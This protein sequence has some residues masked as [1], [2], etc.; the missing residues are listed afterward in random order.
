MAVREAADVATASDLP[1]RWPGSP[2]NGAPPRRCDLAFIL[3][4]LRLGG[5][6]RAAT[7]LIRAW[8]KAGIKVCVITFAGAG[9]DF[10]PLAPGIDRIGLDVQTPTGSLWR[11]LTENVRR[12]RLLRAAIRTTGAGR[13]LSFVAGTN[14]LTVLAT[15]GLRCRVVVSER[16]DPTRQDIGR[17]WARLRRYVYPHAD[18]VTANSTMAIAS[19]TAFVPAERLRLIPNSVEA[20]LAPAERVPERMFLAVGRLTHQKGLDVLLRAFA[21][22][23]QQY[24]WRLTIAG[25]GEERDSLKDLAKSL[26]IGKYV[27][28]VGA[29]ADVAALYRRAGVFVLSSRF[30]GTPNALLEAMA[31][32]IPVIVTDAIS[33]AEMVTAARCGRVVRGN[34]DV[35]L[36]AAMCELAAADAA[37]RQRMGLLAA[38]AVRSQTI[39][40]AL[41]QWDSALRL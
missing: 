9:S 33:A 17:V 30:E 18:L 25:D 11:A 6:Q 3:P 31:S 26:A 38:Q 27:D 23:R 32:G 35:A 39:D 22:T 28:W 36:A 15:R 21:Q 5:A 16:N 29:V 34:D 10:F 1:A 24:P 19:L 37:E 20:P 41:Q 40:V 4:D 8:S 7:H 12:I 2:A 13:V 14:V